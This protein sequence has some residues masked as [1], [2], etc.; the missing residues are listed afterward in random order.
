MSKVQEIM[1][2]TTKAEKLFWYKGN[3]EF[4]RYTPKQHPKAKF[5]PFVDIDV[6]VDENQ[7][8]LNK[9]RV[10]KAPAAFRGN[11]SCEVTLEPSFRSIWVTEHLQVA[12]P[13]KHDPAL[14]VDVIRKYENA[15]SIGLATW[16][17]GLRTRNEQAT[18]ETNNIV[19]L[20]D[21]IVAK[22]SA[23][24]STPPVAL[25][26]LINDDS[27]DMYR[28]VSIKQELKDDGDNRTATTIMTMNVTLQHSHFSGRKI[29]IKCKASLYHLYNATSNEV[30]KESPRETVLTAA[31]YG[32][33]NSRRLHCGIGFEIMVLLTLILILLSSS[34][35]TVFR[36]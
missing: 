25:K 1:K 12:V 35:A 19:N 7:S 29:V 21:T 26:F 33:N 8:D 32:D 10:K 9:I 27:T 3:R 6:E 17:Q 24:P 18:E 34:S 5:I 22:C 16:H 30:K 14:T 11:I 36:L 15:T 2:S 4:F 31:G 28:G 13:P 20:G 23:G